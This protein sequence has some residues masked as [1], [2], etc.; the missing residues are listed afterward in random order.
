VALT[1]DKEPKQR[2]SEAIQDE[3]VDLEEGLQELR[4]KYEQYF[5][6]LD[7]MAPQKQHWDLGKRIKMLK[8]AFI[9]STGLKF[10]V[11]TLHARF[12]SYERMWQRTLN[13]MENGT[14]RRDI[15]KARLHKKE[16]EAKLAEKRADKDAKEPQKA[17]PAAPAPAASVPGGLSDAR[18]RAIYEAYVKAKQDCREDTTKLSLEAVAA[19]LRRQVPDLLKK[20]NAK[21]VDFRVIIKDGKA[22]LRAIPK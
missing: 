1:N 19:S 5:L 11:Q 20:H 12:L 17:V 22:A 2:T 10:R 16:H 18:V 8:S 4:A 6:G 3:C 7:R 21:E 9:Q 15:F 13:E 14:Y